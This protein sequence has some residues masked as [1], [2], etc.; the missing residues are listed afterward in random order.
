LV[1]LNGSFGDGFELGDV[2]FALRDGFCD[3]VCADVFEL[4]GFRG[5]RLSDGFR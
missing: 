4:A 1:F 5:E 3:F 2:S